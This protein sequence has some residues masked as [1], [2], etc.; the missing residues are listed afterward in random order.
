[1]FMQKNRAKS[2]ANKDNGAFMDKPDAG[3]KKLDPNQPIGQNAEDWRFTPQMSTPQ[4][5]NEGHYQS[6]ISGS[7][8]YAVS[9]E[10]HIPFVGTEMDK[11]THSLKSR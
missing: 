6:G 7:G 4:A 2:G 8:I 10:Q 1:M 5:I 3:S 9:Y 11:G